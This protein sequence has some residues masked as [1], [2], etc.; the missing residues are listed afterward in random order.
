MTET[1]I[2][3]WTLNEASDGSPLVNPAPSDL[4][5][6]R[7]DAVVRINAAAHRY[8]AEAV[9][10]DVAT[11]RRLAAAALANVHGDGATWQHVAPGDL[12]PPPAAPVPE[13]L[14]P[15]AIRPGDPRWTAEAETFLVMGGFGRDAEPDRQAARE[16][17]V[18]AA[19][20]E[21]W[22]L[23]R[24]GHAILRERAEAS[25]ALGVIDPRHTLDQRDP[26]APADPGEVW[27]RVT[28]APK[29]GETTVSAAM[30]AGF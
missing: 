4:D 28:R 14:D 20:A 29:P 3:T 1:T 26:L 10:A 27:Q 11:A 5:L 13:R 18:A 6:E 22:S 8:A 2:T 17:L 23:R 15:D 9:R 12:V 16:R 25:E 30:R 21:G 19:L 7:A 24:L